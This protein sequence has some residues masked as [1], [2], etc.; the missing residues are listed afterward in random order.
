MIAV[1]FRSAAVSRCES[2]CILIYRWLTLLWLDEEACPVLLAATSEN[3]YVEEQLV[4]NSCG[5]TTAAQKDLWTIPDIVFVDCACQCIDLCG[6]MLT[7]V[8]WRTHSRAC[9]DVHWSFWVHIRLL[10]ASVAD[11]KGKDINLFHCLKKMRRMRW[12]RKAG[13][14]L[15]TIY[16][17]QPLI[18]VLVCPQLDIH[19]C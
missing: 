8:Q 3:N 19:S 5:R 4:L 7:M 14:D 18:C 13:A 1:T 16:R 10:F 15:V 2:G 9:D 17:P 6:K 11:L 12:I